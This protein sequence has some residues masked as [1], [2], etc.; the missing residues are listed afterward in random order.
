MTSGARGAA[1]ESAALHS[2][3][4]GCLGGRVGDEDLTVSADLLE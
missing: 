1:L 2:E 4:T 3:C